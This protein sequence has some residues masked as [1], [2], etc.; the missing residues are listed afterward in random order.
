MYVC[1]YIYIY[2]CIY[3]H[4]YIYQCSEL[5]VHPAPCVHI[6]TAG[7]TDV[8]TCA[9]GV[10]MLFQIYDVYLYIGK[11]PWT[12]CRVHNFVYRCTLSVH[13]IKSKLQIYVYLC[14]IMSDFNIII[15]KGVPLLMADPGIISH[16]L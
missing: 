7:C 12:N 3:M 16:S 1:I 8:S 15:Y 4:I 9:P 2:I 11:N 13:T 5:M 10:C 6:L 14:G